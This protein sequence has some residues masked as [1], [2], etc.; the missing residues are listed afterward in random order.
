MTTFVRSAVLAA[1]CAWLVL[2]FGCGKEEKTVSTPRGDVTVT[3]R[4]DVTT[5]EVTGK[6]GKFTA[7]SAEGG[8]ALPA[9]FPKDVPIIKGGVVK[10]AMVAG[11]NLSVHV[12]APASVAEAGKY[13]EDSLKAQGWKIEAAMNMGDSM[14][15]SARKGKRECAVTIAK[16]GKGSALQLMVPRGAG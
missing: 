1:A 13:Y 3:T 2:A 8:V 4:G 5:V 6:D 10:M 14:M 12:E 15:I 9:D 11:P 16:E 7:S